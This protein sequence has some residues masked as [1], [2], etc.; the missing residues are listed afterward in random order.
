MEQKYMYE[1][2]AEHKEWLNKLAFYKDEI[3]M[4][5]NRLAEVAK[6]NTDKEV[7]AYVEHFE[8]QLTVQAEQHDIIRHDVKQ[9][10]NFLEEEIKKNPT[11]ADHRKLDDQ[12]KMR[13]TVETFEKIFNDLRHELIGFLAKWM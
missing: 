1:L 8:N 11:A 9:Y 6:K 12:V 7:Q 3:K 5:R 4:M 2:H 10:E 13:D